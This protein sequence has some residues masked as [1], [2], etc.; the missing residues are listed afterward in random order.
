[1][2]LFRCFIRPLA[3]A[4]IV[5]FSFCYFISCKRT[6]ADLPKSV[7]ITTEYN[8]S[9]TC[10]Q[11]YLTSRHDDNKDFLYVAG[12]EGG[13]KIYSLTGSLSLVKTIPTTQLDS[14]EV[15]NLTQSGNY[16]YLALGN[17]FGTGQ[18]NPGM[19][20]IDVTDPVNPVI[21]T[22]WKDPTVVTGAG[23]IAVDGNYAYLG[24][25]RNGLMIF[26]IT[27]KTAPLLMSS[28][29]PSISF[30]DV[31]PD[32]TKYNA[33]GMAIKGDLVYLCYDA[34]GL[35]IINVSDK[36]YPAEVGRYANPVM[37]GKPR[38]YNNIVLDDSLAY[39]AVDYC[40][41]EVLNIK[42]PSAIRLV[43]WWNPWRCET[44]ALNWFV[45]DGHSNEIAID[46]ANK[47][48]FMATG[49]SDMDVI[50]ISNPQKSLPTRFEYGGVNN[51]I[52][53]WGLSIYKNNI[54]LSYIC[55]ALSW[56]FPSNWTGVKLLK[57]E[58]N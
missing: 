51:G 49:K 50:D 19:A 23:I 6:P 44:D 31:N 34:G 41:M 36:S 11:L 55:N 3:G 13:L 1:M 53:T 33:R 2:N 20:I 43:N 29:V 42:D 14:L 56:P 54:Y 27:N 12:K 46:K 9:S 25:M 37:G 21:K 58:V 28:I 48:I 7:S 10:N 17:H 57:Y 39:V 40:G 38:A 52:G 8:L 18:Q 5:L 24:A 45:S 15:M 4:A 26:N 22:V 32:P 47:L 30:P 35:R 16:L